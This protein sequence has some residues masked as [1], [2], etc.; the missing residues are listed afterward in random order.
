MK[1]P[2]TLAAMPHALQARPRRRRAR[3]RARRCSCSCGS[4]APPSYTL[5]ASGLDPADTGKITDGARRP[6][7]SRTSC[8]PTAPPSPSRRRPSPRRGSR[9]PGRRQHRLRL[10]PRLRALRQA[11]ARRDRLP[12]AGHLPARAGGRDRQR[13]ST[14]SR[15]CPAPGPARAARGRPLRR[16]RERRHRRRAA[17]EPGRHARVRRRA[18]HRAAGRLLRQ[19]PQDRQ[20]HDHRRQRARCCGRRATA[21][22]D[23]AGGGTTK[24]AAEARYAQR[25]ESNINAMLTRTLGAGQG[26][27]A[28]Q[29][30]PEHG[31]GHQGR[32]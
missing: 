5:L 8:R 4:P 10:R 3:R 23:G 21:R 2:A 14:P 11:E 22:G 13:R 24:Q 30:R 28:G 1:L 26:P 20:R 9:S 6:G 7:A 29:R 15:A 17:R 12:A 27:G 19:G 25:L 32:R 18:R 16:H 31:Q